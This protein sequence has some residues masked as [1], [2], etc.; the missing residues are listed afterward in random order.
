MA[1][2]MP[3]FGPSIR[4][5]ASSALMPRLMLT[6]N[7]ITARKPARAMPWAAPLVL[8]NTA[9][10]K[11]VAMKTNYADSAVTVSYFNQVSS[12]TII[13]GFGGNGAGW[14]INGGATVAGDLLTLTDGLNNEARSAF[15]NIRQPI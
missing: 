15:F 9:L 6:S 4:A 5:W 8:T 11:A 1:P 3:S 2:T 14:T 13:A 7:S 12:A 10:L